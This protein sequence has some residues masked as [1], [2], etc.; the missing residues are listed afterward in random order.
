MNVHHKRIW[1]K[2]DCVKWILE[3][4]KTT[5]FRSRRHEGLYEIDIGSR[6]KPKPTEGPNAVG[7]GIRL[8]LTPIQTT[9]ASDCITEHY[10]TEGSFNDSYAFQYWLNKNKLNLPNFGWLHKIEILE[11][12][13]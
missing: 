3:G 9:T 6:F 5:T 1:F 13:T 12:P 7:S 4:K 10:K 2:P 11:V 8:R